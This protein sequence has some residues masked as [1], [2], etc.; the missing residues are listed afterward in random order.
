MKWILIYIYIFY[1]TT[2]AVEFDSQQSC[3]AAVKELAKQ[4]RSGGFCV[5]K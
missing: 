4:H 5:Q 1:C 2:F 3:E